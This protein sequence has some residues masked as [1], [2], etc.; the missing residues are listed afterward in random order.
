MPVEINGETI[1]AQI[2]S[3]PAAILNESVVPL[4]VTATVTGKI[5]DG[6]DM[7]LSSS[8]IDPDYTKKKAFIYFE[9]QTTNDPEKVTWDSEYNMDRHIVVRLTPKV[10]KKIVTLDAYDEDG[11][12]KCYGAFRLTGNCA[13]APKIP[14]TD[15][16][17][18]DVTIAFTFKATS[19][20][21]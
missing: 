2:V 9:M 19:K 7:V 4:Q 21:E 3:A 8:S 1:G 18:V 16:D 5:K 6:S 15:A 17:G 11:R 13:A 10:K 12:K 20:V 14:W